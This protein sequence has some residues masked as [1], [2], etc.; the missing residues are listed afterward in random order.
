M[1]P[2]VHTVICMHLPFE[3]FKVEKPTNLWKL[4]DDNDVKVETLWV[5][6][7][8]EDLETRGGQPYRLTEAG[9]TACTLPES[10]LLGPR[11]CSSGCS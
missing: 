5:I 1:G 6:N 8:Y 2:R 10:A 9:L 4:A 3:L 7:T 11:P